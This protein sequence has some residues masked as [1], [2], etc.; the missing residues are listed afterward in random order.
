MISILNRPF[1][2]SEIINN[3]KSV[4]NNKAVGIDFIRNE[5]IKSFSDKLINIYEK[6]FNII[7]IQI[8]MIYNH[9]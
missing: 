4:K 1:T 3:I 8:R 2:T 7:L 6:L 5:Y 9:K